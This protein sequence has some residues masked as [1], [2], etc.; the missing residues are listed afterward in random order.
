VERSSGPNRLNHISATTSFIRRNNSV[1]ADNVS[2][3]TDNAGVYLRSI[4]FFEMFEALEM[5]THLDLMGS[6]P[7][8]ARLEATRRTL[9]QLSHCQN[10]VLRITFRHL[11]AFQELPEQEGREGIER[12]LY[13]S[14]V[15]LQAAVSIG[16]ESLVDIPLEAKLYGKNRKWLEIY[17]QG[18]TIMADEVMKR[19]LEEPLHR[20]TTLYFEALMAKTRQEDAETD[21]EESSPVKSSAKALAQDVFA[22]RL[23]GEYYN[24]GD[25]TKPREIIKQDFLAYRKELLRDSLTTP[26][27]ADK[28]SCK[29]QTLLNWVKKG[30]VL[31]I[32]EKGVWRFPEWQFDPREDEHILKG[33]PDVL[34]ML[35]GSTLSKLSWFLTPKHALEELTPVQALQRGM[36]TEVLGEARGTGEL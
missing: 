5:S 1:I 8:E 20:Y 35:E 24:A 6:T 12:A 13:E 17:I 9:E 22:H 27:L 10:E 19:C 25:D 2:I 33:L 7:S 34:K 29:T 4:D 21:K 32:K 16:N 18:I 15:I 11:P 26:E 28:L 31:A 14:F 36:L 3:I 23:A 30:K